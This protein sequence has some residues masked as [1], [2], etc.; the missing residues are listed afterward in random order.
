MEN[1]LRASFTFAINGMLA[2]ATQVLMDN[3]TGG[4]V[5]GTGDLQGSPWAGAPHH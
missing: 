2:R 1:Q 3:Q 5:I 4:L